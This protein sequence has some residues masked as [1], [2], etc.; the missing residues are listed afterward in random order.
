M[1]QTL[2]PAM[3]ESAFRPLK[4][5]LEK[6]LPAQPYTAEEVRDLVAACRFGAEVLD[7][8]RQRLREQLQR[9]VESGKLR[10][11]LTEFEGVI[12]LAGQKVYPQ[13]RLLSAGDPALPEEEKRAALQSLDEFVRRAAAMRSELDSLRQFLDRP[14]EPVDVEAIL[15]RGPS[16]GERYV[17]IEEVLARLKAGEDV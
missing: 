1:T 5:R 17:D 16:A 11:L 15:G 9:G 10:R 7:S 4:E 3:A 13:A 8:V 14:R 12:D 2:L 6:A